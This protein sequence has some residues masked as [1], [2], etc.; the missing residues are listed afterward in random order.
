[1]N[2]GFATEILHEFEDIDLWIH[3]H[4][5]HC[6]DYMKNNIR[7][8]SNQYGYDKNELVKDFS[9]EKTIKYE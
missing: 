1:M 6:V 8:V 5:H 4:T 7:V 9:W 2:T 3:G